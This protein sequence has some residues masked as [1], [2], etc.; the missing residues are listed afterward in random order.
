MPFS[1]RHALSTSY[2]RIC[3]YAFDGLARLRAILANAEG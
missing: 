2:R 1:P 3:A